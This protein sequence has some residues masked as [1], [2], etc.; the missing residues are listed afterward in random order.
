MPV[1]VAVGSRGEIFVADRQ[2]HR[3]QRLSP[4]GRPLASYGGQSSKAGGLSYPETVAVASDRFFVVDTGN[5][6]VQMCLLKTGKFRVIG[7]RGVAAGLQL[8]DPQG[9]AVDEVRG[10]LF[11]TDA[12]YN[13]LLCVSLA[14]LET[15]AT[16]GQSGEV[17]LI[18]PSCVAVDRDGFVLVTSAKARLLSIVSPQGA[19]VKQ[20]G[21]DVF[22]SPSGV[23]V[24]EW[25][26]VVVA[27]T[28][29]PCIH[30]F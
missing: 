10:R 19:K 26:G 2:N 7:G 11:I 12:G 5:H 28:A 25:G 24:D 15:L 1:G 4:E 22:K 27:D 20:L 18:S 29:V 30:I 6:C 13:C 3:V 16:F 8:R 17:P 21:M 9:V 14:T 23:C